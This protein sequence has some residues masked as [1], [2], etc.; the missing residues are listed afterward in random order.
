MKEMAQMR[1]L[2]SNQ[3]RTCRTTER[4][5]PQS[6]EDFNGGTIAAATNLTNIKD[7]HQQSEENDFQEPNSPV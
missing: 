6:T 3:A 5:K 1:Q 2:P 4:A 7:Q